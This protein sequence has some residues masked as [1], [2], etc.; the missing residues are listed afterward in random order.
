MNENELTKLDA[1]DRKRNG[2]QI[3]QTDSP[4]KGQNTT[5]KRA[6]RPTI[7]SFAE[8][9][10]TTYGARGGV[11]TLRKADTKALLSA[12]P[13]NE[14]ERDELL[15]LAR[16]DKTLEKSKQL[17]LLSMHNSEASR[18][19]NLLREFVLDVMRRHILCEQQAIADLL[20]NLH[21]VS[22]DIAVATLMTSNVKLLTEHNENPL[23]K[24]QVERCV[25]N[26][27]HCLLLLLWMTQGASI[28]RIQHCLQRYVW[29]PNAER[30]RSEKQKLEA[31]VTSRDPRTAS[32]TFTLLDRRLL[33]QEQRTQAATRAEEHARTRIGQLEQQVVEVQ[34]KLHQKTGECKQLRHELCESTEAHATKE[35][36]WRNQYETLKGHTL[37]RL[38]EES[39]LLEEGLHALRR[40]PPKIGVMID[41]AERAIDGLKQ[42]AERIRRERLS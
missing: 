2:E 8:L 35:A 1:G 19:S 13:L 4:L 20:A 25:T 7:S 30:Y 22:M 5:A 17:M 38:N 18:I 10:R 28:E 23:P 6:K 41:H 27:V 40:E 21:S 33:E 15:E 9:I 32:V 42:A 39:S 31:L 14:S 36:H 24:T 26:A 11:K 16:S 3:Q 37:R 29:G 12:P 34:E